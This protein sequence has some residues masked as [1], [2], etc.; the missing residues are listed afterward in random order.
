VSDDDAQ[1]LEHGRVLAEAV[2]DALP[3][4]VERCVQQR[5]VE[6][7]VD[8]DEVAAAARRAGADCATEVG[9][10]VTEL[11]TTDPDDQTTTPLALL[12]EAVGYPT[13]VLAAAGVPPVDRDDFARRSFP[14]DVYDL[15][16]ATVA[17]LDPGLHDLAI[18]WGAARAW[19]HRRRHGGGE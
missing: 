10:A 4:W 6:A 9:G 7:G 8:F 17:D 15:S 3:G 19:V 2:V 1:L 11:L 12:R 14:D 18:T 13:G 5:C 16:P